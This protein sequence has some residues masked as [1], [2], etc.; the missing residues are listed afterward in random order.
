M[1]YY[2]ATDKHTSTVAPALSNAEFHTTIADTDR[3]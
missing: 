1:Q 2:E 3:C